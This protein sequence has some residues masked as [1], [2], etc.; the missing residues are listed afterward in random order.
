MHKTTVGTL[1]GASVASRATIL[2][3]RTAGTVTEGVRG[4]KAIDGTPA[5]REPPSECSLPSSQAP[6]PHHHPKRAGYY[7]QGA[8]GA[9]HGVC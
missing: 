7:I 9:S 5:L 1:G 4:T 3:P 6:H 2:Q 8:L